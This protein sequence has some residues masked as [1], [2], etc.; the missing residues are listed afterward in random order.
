MEKNS[1]SRD[2]ARNTTLANMQSKGIDINT[3]LM[4]ELLIEKTERCAYLE[5]LV[6]QSNK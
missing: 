3:F 2:N 1:N 4:Y 5:S 6:E